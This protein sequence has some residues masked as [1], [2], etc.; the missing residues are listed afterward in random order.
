MGCP[1][2]SIEMYLLRAKS[3]KK[4]RE[5]N[6]L[7]MNSCRSVFLLCWSVHLDIH[8]TRI[9]TRGWQCWSERDR[10]HT[11][12]G[13]GTVSINEHSKEVQTPLP[14]ELRGKSVCLEGSVSQGW[15]PGLWIFF[16]QHSSLLL[17]LWTGR[18]WIYCLLALKAFS[19]ATVHSKMPWMNF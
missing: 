6:L 14:M 5:I 19:L 17:S 15:N 3:S 9:V 18:K 1:Q 13:G 11:L 7:R 2:Y 16:K 8:P 10:K 4:I 12:C